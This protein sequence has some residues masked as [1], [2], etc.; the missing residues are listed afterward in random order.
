MT[1]VA[2]GVTVVAVFLL[3]FGIALAAQNDKSTDEKAVSALIESWL[4]AHN[5]G[6]ARALAGFYAED[7][8][9]VGIDGQVVKGRDAVVAMYANVFA[10]LPGNKA[11]ISLS[12]RRFITPDTVVDDGKWEVIGVL[13]KG[14]PTKGRYTT[15]LKKQDGKWRILCARTMVPVTQTAVRP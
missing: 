1:R 3:T 13:P 14:A 7:A 2:A 11:K 9:F 15:I 12:S 5:Q 6:D 4:A 10:Q 8:D